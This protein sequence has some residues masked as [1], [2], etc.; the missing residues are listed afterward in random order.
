[1]RRGKQEVITRQFSA[2]IR[3]SPGATGV[4]C[5]SMDLEFQ[6]DSFDYQS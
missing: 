1:M 3:S 6:H 4:A 2:K 5:D